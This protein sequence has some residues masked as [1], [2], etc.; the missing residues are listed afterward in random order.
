MPV[1]QSLVE[2]CFGL[3][4]VITSI[5]RNI[6]VSLYIWWMESSIKCPYWWNF[7]PLRLDF[8]V[9]YSTSSLSSLRFHMLHSP[10]MPSQ[11]KKKKAT[12]HDGASYLGEGLYH[13]YEM[14]RRY[15]QTPPFP[16]HSW[17][18]LNG[19]P[20]PRKTQLT[21]LCLI[22]TGCFDL[23]KYSFQSQNQ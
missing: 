11:K 19:C 4:K 13:A 16:S 7:V 10:R 9:R 22:K 20:K 5:N 3:R 2:I 6:L 17:A 14:I 21:P 18:S 15:V 23:P 1:P 12:Q 8:P